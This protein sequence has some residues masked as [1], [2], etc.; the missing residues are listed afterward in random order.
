M[1]KGVNSWKM[2]RSKKKSE[3]ESPDKNYSP[4]ELSES[5]DLSFA[6]NA[7]LEI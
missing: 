3:G 4:P 6:K 1:G 7:T 2:M 5:L